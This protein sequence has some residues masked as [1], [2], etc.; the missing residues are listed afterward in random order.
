MS[1]E[2]TLLAVIAA[3]YLA[4]CLFWIPRNG[5]GF[6]RWLG[7]FWNIR[8][9][10]TIVGNDRGALGFANPLPPLGLATRAA[11]WT[12]SISERGV[13][14]YAS[15]A[16]NPGGRAPQKAIFYEWSKIE[17]VQREEKE[18]WMNGKLFAKAV[19]E[20][21]AR[22]MAA[23]VSRLQKCAGKKRAAEIEKTIAA[24]CD[25]VEVTR[26]V[27]EFQM[28]SWAL[29]YLSNWL[30]VFLFGACPILVWRL[31]MVGA[32]WPMVIGI[33]L[34]T[35]VIALV[36]SKVHRKLYASDSGQIFKPFLTMLLAAPSAIRAHDIL[37]R[38]LLESFHPVAVAKALCRSQ[39]F[40][41]FASAPIRDLLFP[42][43]PVVPPDSP[44]AAI[45]VEKDF[46]EMVLKSLKRKLAF[47]ETEF[48]KAPEK[49]ETV[50][51]AYCPRCLQQFT[52]AATS[53][54][55]CGGRPLVK[56]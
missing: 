21:S 18:I 26:R 22:W 16:F 20:Y 1:D 54:P 48:L 51:T 45:A 30:F 36:F 43:M 5:L 15:A 6:T 32:I 17:S 31:G 11:G 40:E 41:S 38:P 47:D 37:G 19:T 2:Q 42:R 28:Q 44:E 9:P 8:V 14:S 3:I 10:S 13:F 4:D 24:S 52:E 25:P 27:K 56:F 7:K 39:D 35:I 12:I 55:D 23:E 46:R 50:H 34:Q 49:T 33:Y 29:K 53:C